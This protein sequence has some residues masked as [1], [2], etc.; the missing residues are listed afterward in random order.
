M[1]GK[2]KRHTYW[3]S[4]EVSFHISKSVPGKA[5]HIAV[6]MNEEEANKQGKQGEML[7]A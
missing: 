4:C 2:V 5:P 3:S 1:P 6:A 7:D